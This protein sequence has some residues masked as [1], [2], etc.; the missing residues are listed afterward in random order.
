[1]QFTVV[2]MLCLTFPLMTAAADPAAAPVPVR[3]AKLA[4]VVVD[5]ESSAPAEVLALN[6]AT[7]SAQLAAVIT[8]IHADVGQSVQSGDLLLEL[9]A[10]DYELA[11]QQAQAALTSSQAQKAQ[12]DA[13]L[14]RA[15][16]LGQQQYLSDDELLARETDVAVLAAQILSQQVQLAIARRQLSKTRILAP[17]DGA[18]TGRMAQLGAYVT[19]GSP[20]LSLS[21]TARFELDA[22]VPDALADTL[23]RSSNMRFVSRNE[24]WPVEL[25]RLSPLVEAPLRSRRARL[26][27]SGS[28]PPVGRSG[29]LVWRV[30][31]GLLPVNL[32]VRREGQLGVFL[33]RGG[34]AQFTPLPGAQEGRPVA[35]DLPLDSDIVV[36]GRERLQPGDAIAVSQ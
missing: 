9:D 4:T 13:R 17:F 30:E 20:L 29:E 18:V 16:E 14:T 3:V 2:A 24:S 6:A 26:A 34:I 8:G 36:D 22:Q 33:A 31:K 25:I 1:M 32:V 15:R 10:T 5:L 12:A 7:L 23:L 21:E 35:I 11:V 28:A 19:P 27:F